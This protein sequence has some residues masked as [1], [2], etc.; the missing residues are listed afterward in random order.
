MFRLLPD[1]VMFLC[2]DALCVREI[3]LLSCTCWR[4]A[5]SLH[6]SGA[7]F[8]RV[9][10]L[11]L[12]PVTFRRAYGVQRLIEESHKNI[13]DATRR[14]QT[15]EWSARSIKALRLELFFATSHKSLCELSLT[16]RDALPPCLVILRLL[17]VCTLVW[18]LSLFSNAGEERNLLYVRDEPEELA[19]DLCL[20][21][22]RSLTL[23]ISCGSAHLRRVLA[24][25]P[26]L[27]SLS[28]RHALV[29]ISLGLALTGAW[30]FAMSPPPL[31]FLSLQQ[32]DMNANL[33][34][35]LLAFP[36]LEHIVLELDCWQCV[37]CAEE[38]LSRL[39]E[40]PDCCPKLRRLSVL[41]NKQWK[42]TQGF[43]RVERLRTRF[44]IARV[45]CE[46]EIV[47]SNTVAKR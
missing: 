39:C 3:L 27:S 42:Y 26:N 20:P 22:I 6:T 1:C 16:R 10:H 29:D 33:G 34:P 12:V 13:L 21:Q 15:L 30:E 4:M 44:A 28:L 36:S 23:G 41:A 17:R 2:C 32:V 43:A 14:V 35:A 19:A 7:Y 46:F 38:E 5:A 25:L 40:T 37:M 31:Q 18:K 24:V 9:R 47:F 45:H 8:Q 11:Q